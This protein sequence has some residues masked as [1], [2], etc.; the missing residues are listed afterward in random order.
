MANG[1][2]SVRR[3]KTNARSARMYAKNSIGISVTS[4]ITEQLQRYEKAIKEKVIR[5]AARAGALVFYNEMRMLVPVG[6]GTLFNAIYHWHDDKKSRNGSH[7]Y[8]IGP[9]KRKAPHWAF[10]EYGH[11]RYNVVIRLPNGQFRA[12]KER[13][14]SPVW[15]PAQPY[16]RPA[17]TGKQQTALR[18]M[19]TK[20]K[21]KMREVNSEMQT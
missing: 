5:P 3:G 7:T 12:T 16:V 19:L 15:V 1:R 18:A 6:E 8:A 9:N 4:N 20:M 17:W 21:E 14:P 10:I 11:F 2:N 13:L